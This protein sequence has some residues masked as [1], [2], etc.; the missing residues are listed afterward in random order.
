[1]DE[2]LSLILPRPLGSCARAPFESRDDVIPRAR[3]PHGESAPYPSR[4]SS[5]EEQELD[6]T[7]MDK[8]P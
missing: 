2:T 7:A 5:N 6:A 8:L 4:G 1:M 3:T